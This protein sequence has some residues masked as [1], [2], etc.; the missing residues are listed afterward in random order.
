MTHWKTYIWDLNREFSKEEQIIWEI[1]QHMFTVS[2]YY[3]IVT[4]RNL[5]VFIIAH[6][7]GKYQPKK[8]QQ[9]LE[10]MWDGNFIL[11]WC[12]CKLV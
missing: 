8:W 7:I 5:W 2:T 3:G 1:S 9:M 6:H 12:E 10:E 11:C 4:Q